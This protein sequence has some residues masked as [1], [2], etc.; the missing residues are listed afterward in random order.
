VAAV[1]LDQV[2]KTYDGGVLAV[3]GVDLKVADGELLVL[4]G[5]S[6]CG[7]TT[8]LRLIAGLEQ[9]TAGDLW[10][11]GEYAN[12]RPPQR[13]N[14]AMVF[15]HG[16][17]YPHLTVAENLAF[18]LETAGEEDREAIDAR[19][20]E[21]AHGLGLD[22]KL[23]RRPA[24][25]SGGERQ[26]VAMGRAL[27]R[28]TP[29]VLLMDEPLASLD[30]ALRADLRA[31]IGGLVR[32]MHL[33]T[34]YVTHDQSEALSLAD[35]IVVLR[36]GQIEDVGPPGRVYED[37][38]TAFVAA[39]MGSPP[40]NLAW[41]KVWIVNGDRV[42]VDLGR[43]RLELPWTDP[44]SESLTPYHGQSVIVGIR[45][46]ALLPGPGGPAGTVLS[47]RVSAL[48]FYG[49]E[50]LARLD[51]GLRP[52][53]LDL[54]RPRRRTVA[55][56]VPAAVGWPRPFAAAPVADPE[57]REG[58]HH[59]PGQHESGQHGAGHNGVGQHGAGQHSAGQHS[60]GQHSAGHHG[61][62]RHGGEHRS[63]ALLLR[64]TSPGAW[65][66]G[67]EAS[68]AVDLARLQI[69][70]GRGRRIGMTAVQTAGASS[71]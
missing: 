14:I 46:E 26:R 48:E 29:T 50:W 56:V 19:V 10:L 43:Q 69:F 31:E 60:A 22:A 62:D 16:A 12:D 65:A 8:I 37:P 9:I 61:G 68:V 44:R 7:K 6:G 33:T 5:P 15:Q 58:D 41:G 63:A 53:D 36:D 64:V 38:A 55:E 30:V 3:D 71:A 40:I 25:L 51:A 39:F 45:P 20:R 59:R 23:D 2:S 47:G 34:V 52:V 13:R 67:Q 18:P 35:R 21:M 54:L 1:V 4:L 17:L 66:P 27:I 32:S 11:D 42:I 57:A 24:V 49:H 70:D 28:G